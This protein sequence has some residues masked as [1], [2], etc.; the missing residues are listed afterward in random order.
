M[1]QSLII[2]LA[3]LSKLC[4]KAFKLNVSIIFIPGPLLPKSANQ[5]IRI[6]MAIQTRASSW[7]RLYNR[8]KLL[9]PFLKQKGKN[10][11]LNS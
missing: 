7:I 11:F 1:Q 8:R 4:Y 2:L 6:I 3:L 10:I 5:S 9:L